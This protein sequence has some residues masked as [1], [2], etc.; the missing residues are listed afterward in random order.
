VGVAVGEMDGDGT[1]EASTLATSRLSV[2]NAKGFI[3]ILSFD[4]SRQII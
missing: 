4:Q 1:K 3:I 2:N